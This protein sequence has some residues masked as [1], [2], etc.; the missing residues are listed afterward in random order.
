MSIIR[1]SRYWPFR[2]LNDFFDDFW[3]VPDFTLMRIPR[4]TFPK[5]DIKEEEGNYIITAEVPGYSKE[6]VNIEIK[7]DMLTIFSE[8]EEKK[9]EEKAGYIYKERSHRSFCRS[10]RIPENITHEEI[11]ADLKDG[12]LTLRIPKKEPKLPKKVEIE[13][14]KELTDMEVKE[15]E[16]EEKE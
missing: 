14:H 12:L 2:I 1:R 3:D 11:K 6:E 4:M 5:L 15:A 10:L 9:D 7:N 8:H 16:T 13:E